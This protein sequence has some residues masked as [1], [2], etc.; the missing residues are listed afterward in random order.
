MVR[1]LGSLSPALFD[2]AADAGQSGDFFAPGVLVGG[3]GNGGACGETYLDGVGCFLVSSMFVWM[4][5]GVCL[6]V[7]FTMS[8][9]ISLEIGV[10]KDGKKSVC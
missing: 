2:P 3:S 6:C 4:F 5:L 1:L 9:W 10:P 7:S 8:L